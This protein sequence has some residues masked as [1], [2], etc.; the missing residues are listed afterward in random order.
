MQVTVDA[1]DS[2][3]LCRAIK[4][5]AGELRREAKKLRSME[6][7]SE[8][9]NLDAEAIDLAERLGPMFDEQGTFSFG[10][11]PKGKKGKKEPKDDAQRALELEQKRAQHRRR[12]RGR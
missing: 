3:T 9:Q 4:L 6:R 5:R 12:G 8:A 1:N 2:R 11:A 10:P 7:P